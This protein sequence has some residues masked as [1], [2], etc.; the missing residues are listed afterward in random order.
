[1]S[2]E[3]SLSL[4]EADAPPN[5]LAL[6][7]QW[8]LDAEK[9]NLVEPSAMT[10]ATASREGI[11]DARMVLLRGFDERG[12]VFYTNYESRKAVELAENPLAALVLYWGP[13]TRQIR[14]E[15]TVAKLTPEESDA[16]FRS[17]PFGHKLG[18]L[19]SPQSQVIPDRTFLEARLQELLARHPS[20]ADVP[21]PPHWGGYRVTPHTIEFWQGRANRLHD[22]LRYRKSADGWIIERLAP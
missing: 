1:M 22:R 6:F 2:T 21:R 9:A 8:I 19:A 14:I 10:L 16:Y 7:A 4:S 3:S 11:P 17:R 12:F 5:P 13:L 18:A 20:D 15:G